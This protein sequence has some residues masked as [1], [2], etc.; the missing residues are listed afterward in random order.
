[1]GEYILRLLEA[2]ASYIDDGLIESCELIMMNNNGSDIDYLWK[3]GVFTYGMFVDIRSGESKGY[4]F[5]TIDDI[6]EMFPQLY[7]SDLVED[8]S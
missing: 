7:L 8:N 1:M 2:C 4:P 3:S 5:R 6:A